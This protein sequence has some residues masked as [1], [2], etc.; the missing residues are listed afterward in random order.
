MLWDGVKKGGCVCGQKKIKDCWANDQSM[1]EMRVIVCNVQNIRKTRDDKRVTATGGWPLDRHQQKKEEVG[2]ECL[3]VLYLGEYRAMMGSFGL[4]RRPKE[5]S[6]WNNR[7]V[8]KVGR[9][10]GK[11]EEER[12]KKFFCP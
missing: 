3:V 10:S 12:V 8:E 5:V 11:R 7:R 1:I 9:E 2:D 6:R 4:R